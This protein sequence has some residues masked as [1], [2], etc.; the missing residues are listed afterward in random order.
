MNSNLTG[1][2]LAPLK[3]ALIYRASCR[4]RVGVS[5]SPAMEREIIKGV[6]ISKVEQIKETSF[7]SLSLNVISAV[8]FKVFL[9]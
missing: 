9:L 4:S 7:S 5:V 2:S 3:A 8:F 1:I 6:C